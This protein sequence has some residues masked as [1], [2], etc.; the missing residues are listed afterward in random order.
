MSAI[1][2]VPK[3]VHVVEAGNEVAHALKAVMSV[4]GFV[5]AGIVGVVVKTPGLVPAAL[6]FKPVM[7]VCGGVWK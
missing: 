7:L 3:P 1:L 6:G 5:D 2:T 4:S